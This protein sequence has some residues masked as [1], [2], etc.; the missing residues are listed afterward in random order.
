MSSIGHRNE[1][2]AD[3][4]PVGDALAGNRLLPVYSEVSEPLSTS[5]G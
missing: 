4:Y 2:S 1:V 5:R 3:A